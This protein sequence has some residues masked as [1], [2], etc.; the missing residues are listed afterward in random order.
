MIVPVGRHGIEVGDLQSHPIV[1]V[2]PEDAVDGAWRGRK[3]DGLGGFSLDVASVGQAA[4]EVRGTGD[5]AVVGPELGPLDLLEVSGLS[6][7]EELVDRRDRQVVDQV[8]G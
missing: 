3:Y 5:V 7:D 6:L 4:A 1:A 2:V 8:R